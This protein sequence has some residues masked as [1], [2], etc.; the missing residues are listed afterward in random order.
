MKPSIQL[1]PT[2]LRHYR[3]RR[4]LSLKL[5]GEC[6]R[7]KPSQTI[8]SLA[9]MYERVERTGITSPER[10]QTIAVMLGVDVA[11]LSGERGDEGFGFEWWLESNSSTCTPMLLQGTAQLMSRL[12]D[13]IEREASFDFHESP[14]VHAR[15]HITKAECKLTYWRPGLPQIEPQ[16]W[17]I[18]PARRIETGIT[19]LEF[20]QHELEVLSE[21]A[22]STAGWSADVV[23]TKGRQEPAVGSEVGYS[24]RHVKSDERLALGDR[25]TDSYFETTGQLCASLLQRFKRTGATSAYVSAD[26]ECLTVA[27]LRGEGFF[28]AQRVWRSTARSKWKLC[29][30]RSASL[31]RLGE[32]LKAKLKRAVPGIQFCELDLDAKT[33]VTRRGQESSPP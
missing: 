23:H 16:W 18:R 2:I 20:T 24:L 6:L 33:F 27:P 11:V 15:L 19:W 17:S 14:A 13:S 1:S 30:W 32:E 26:R 31:R 4:G 21:R 3:L 5:S 10:A 9:N 28:V 29:P 25:I 12:W 7:K 22:R 8:E